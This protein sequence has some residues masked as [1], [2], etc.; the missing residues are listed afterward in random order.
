M[1]K[2]LVHRPLGD[3][4]EHH[5]I[6]RFCGTLG[7]DFLGKMLTNRLALSIRVSRKVNSVGRFGCLLQFSNDSLVITLAGIR[8]YFVSR[9]EIVVDI[10]A[11]SFRR[12][13]FDV[14]YRALTTCPCQVLF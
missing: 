10:D 6:G 1:F 12:Q 11:Q 14:A 9:F 2:S 4:I 8:N 5:A 7:N 13:I 3:L